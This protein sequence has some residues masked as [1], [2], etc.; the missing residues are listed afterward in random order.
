MTVPSLLNTS[1]SPNRKA[2]PGF[3]MSFPILCRLV[4]VEVDLKVDGN[5]VGRLGL[6][7]TCREDV[8]VD[9]G[10]IVV[11]DDSNDRFAWLIRLS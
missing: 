10:R 1:A 11:V 6:D 3:T 4:R 2:A 5:M 9:I 8:C 7:R